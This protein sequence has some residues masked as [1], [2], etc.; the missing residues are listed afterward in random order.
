VPGICLVLT[1]A[2]AD[3][4]RHATSWGH[5]TLRMSRSDSTGIVRALSDGNGPMRQVEIP[6]GHFL[7]AGDDVANSVWYRVSAD[8]NLHWLFALVKY[9]KVDLDAFA[10]MI[11]T[12]F[13]QPGGAAYYAIT[14]VPRAA[15]EECA[16]NQDVEAPEF[17]IWYV[18]SEGAV[19][20]D[21][22]V[23]TE[24]TGIAVL[25]P[26]WPV[27]YVRHGRVLLVGAGSIGGAAAQAMATAGIGMLHLLDPGRLRWHNLPRHVCGPRHVGKLKVEALRADLE[28]TRT[29]TRIVTHEYNVIRHTDAVRD[30]LTEI[31]VIVCTAD[32]VL[33][34]RVVSHLARRVGIPAVLACVLADGAYG[35]LMR[36]WPWPDH[37]CYQCRL[38]TL[39]E[40]G[41]LVP[42][43]EPGSGYLAQYHAMTAVG[44]DLHLVGQLAGK[45]AIA[46]YLQRKGQHDQWFA[47]EHAVLALRPEPGWSAPYDLTQAGQIEWHSATPPRPGCP[48]CTNVGSA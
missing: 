11:P 40:T 38:D 19:P 35:D 36:L 17:A 31:D 14:Y 4:I 23:Q 46:T 13:R 48:T 6:A 47:G 21:I 34:R 37:G 25:T 18:S 1:S 33:P 9:S 41:G 27:E 29:D 32:G 12:G 8:V 30:L 22:D 43:H 42:A 5:M 28:A 16:E 44:T 7:Q 3:A 26:H 24:R 45:M 20:L 15:I 39:T 2:A 10:S